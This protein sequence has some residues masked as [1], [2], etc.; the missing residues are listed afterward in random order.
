MTE[1]KP[2][3]K[4]SGAATPAAGS[5]S[6]GAQSRSTAAAATRERIVATARAL[7]AE[8]G[9][10]GTTTAAIA[11]RAHIAEGTIY[12]HFGSK[13][14]LFVACVEPVVAET[15]RRGLAEF[16]E[17]HD[18]RGFVR[19]LINMR[20]QMFEAHIETFNILFT[21]APYH[22]ELAELL[23]ERVL[24][25]RVVQSAPELRRLLDSPE[26]QRPPNFLYLGIGLT[27]AIWFILS[28]REKLN[29]ITKR[30]P[31]PMRFPTPVTAATMVDDLT[32]FVLYGIAG[33][34]PASSGQAPRSKGQPGGS[35]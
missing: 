22:P 13:K 31:P 28:S 16:T 2:R 17:A 8:S 4:P 21:E 15:F 9:Y 14:E 11:G 24:V 32:D 6:A 30:L 5:R 29:N 18:L 35:K 12:R 7:F 23:L 34:A 33:Q 3:R 20:L 10:D 26:L 19:A 27:A 1:P 25:D